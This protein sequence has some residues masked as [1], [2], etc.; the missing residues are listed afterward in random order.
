MKQCNLTKGF[1]IF[2]IIMISL[3]CGVIPSSWAD[4]IVV[5]NWCDCC[6][7]QNFEGCY[8][9]SHDGMIMMMV[10]EQPNVLPLPPLP[11]PPIPPIPMASVG[12]FYLDERGNLTGHEMVNFGGTSFRTKI[13]GKYRVNSDCTGTAW[14]CST[15]ANGDPGIKSTISFVIA[16]PKLDELQMVTTKMTSCYSSD[17]VAL[18]FNIVGIAK[19]QG[20]ATDDNEQ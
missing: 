20:C 14:I 15:P 12:V 3:F 8:G 19:K 16:G 11:T 13:R 5:S 18:P 10:S 4:D 17:I 7:N 6:E 9:F 1:A 2:L